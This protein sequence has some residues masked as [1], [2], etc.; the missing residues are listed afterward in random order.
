MK[1]RHEELAARLKAARAALGLKQE[2]VVAISGIPIDSYRKY[3]GG[4]SR[5]GAGAIA[6]LER[7]GISASWLTSGE[8]EML[9]PR[10]LTAQVVEQPSALPAYVGATKSAEDFSPDWSM[11]EVVLRVCEVKLTE[12]MTKD[13]ADKIGQLASAWSPIAEGRPDLATRLERVRTAAALLRPG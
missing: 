1:V 8:G 13:I 11:L 3:E 12:P 4:R 5:P 7:A 2:E 6:K 10:K 9:L